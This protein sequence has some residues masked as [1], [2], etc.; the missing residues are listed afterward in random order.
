VGNRYGMSGGTG[1]LAGPWRRVVSGGCRWLTYKLVRASQPVQDP[2]SGLFAMQRAVLTGADLRPDG[3]KILL[4]VIARGTWRTAANIDYT[5][6]ARTAG[7]SKA[8]L[9][10]GWRFVRLLARLRGDRAEE[11][12]AVTAAPPTRGAPVLIGARAHG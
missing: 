6:A 3:Y 11:G 8:G 2:L 1:G 7:D 4:E 12:Q 9:R 5:F 10:E